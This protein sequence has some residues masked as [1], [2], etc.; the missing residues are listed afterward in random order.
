MRFFKDKPTL[1]KCRIY[2]ML[3]AHAG[4]KHLSFHTPGHKIGKWD[5]TELSFSDNLRS[6]TG[7]I[8]QAEEEIAEILGSTRSFITTDGSTSGVL[9][10][11]YAL[12]SLGVAQIAVGENSHESVWKSCALLGLTPLVY[13][14]VEEVKTL[15]A[16]AVLVTSPSYYG[17]V[18]KLSVL[19]KYC[20]E[21]G[22][23]LAV[24]GAHG[25][26]LHFDKTLHAS[27]YADLW[28]DG[29]HKSLPALTQGAVVSAR[30]EACANALRAGVEIFRTTSPSYPI[31][32]SVEYAVKYPRNEKLEKWVWEWKARQPRLQVFEDY[33]KIGAPF[34]KNAFAVQR[35]LEG[36]GIYPEFCD[37]ELLLFYLSPASSLRSVKRLEK[38]LNALF[39]KY[40]YDGEN[41]AQRNPAPLLL[42]ADGEIEWVNLTESEGRICARNCGLFPP[43]TPLLRAGARISAEDIE[44]LRAATN[45]YGLTQGKIAAI[46]EKTV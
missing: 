22:L 21:R 19:R 23:Y 8:A 36:K 31:M 42:P 44:K 45:T 4:K 37:G 41:Q 2:Q 35:E 10:M 6:P 17:K 27:G 38:A 20:D 32:A 28:V 43:C 11:L 25:G 24:D 14:E 33:T 39:Q 29:V 9:S 13:T 15:P 34:G 30:G 40:P 12:K 16:Q 46:K 7:C 3:K 26:H 1:R 5:I 18:E